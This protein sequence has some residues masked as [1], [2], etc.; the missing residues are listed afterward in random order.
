ML[1]P[2]TGTCGSQVEIGQKHHRPEEQTEI[3]ARRALR[4]A[5]GRRWS[6]HRST[7]CYRLRA[8][9][10]IVLSRRLCCHS[11]FMN[12]MF[13]SAYC[14]GTE[15]WAARYGPTALGVHVRF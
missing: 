1:V 9:L 12:G 11:L 4:T 5:Q 10:P 6:F 13:S 14:Y 2:A 3:S 7:C 8:Q 15:K